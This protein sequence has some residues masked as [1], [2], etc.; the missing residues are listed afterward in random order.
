[1]LGNQLPQIQT[2]PLLVTKSTIYDDNF[3]GRRFDYSN[4]FDLPL[5]IIPLV[6]LAP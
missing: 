5:K 3:R 4:W 6:K 1:V 2:M